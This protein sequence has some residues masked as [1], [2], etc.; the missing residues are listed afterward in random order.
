MRPQ[1]QL[2]VVIVV[3]KEG[4][5]GREDDTGSAAPLLHCCSS[6]IISFLYNISSLKHYDIVCDPKRLI[7]LQVS[8][9][10]LKR[11]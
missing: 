1:G 6:P 10:G 5:T 9:P 7:G 11:I 4:D 8:Y 2:G 3:S